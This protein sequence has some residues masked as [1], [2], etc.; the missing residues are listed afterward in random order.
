MSS[1]PQQTEPPVQP[2]HRT[3]PPFPTTQYVP[4]RALD[5]IDGIAYALHLFLGSHMIESEQ[6]CRKYDPKMERLYFATGF[7]LIQCVKGLMS[8]EDEDLVDAIAHVRHGNAIASQHRKRAASLPTRLA[9]LVVGSL[10]TS[11]VGFIKSMTPVERH[12]ELVYAE[13]LFEKALL[14]IVYSG[15]WLAFIKEALNMRTTINIYRQLGKYLDAVDAEAQ[16]RGLGPE[17]RAVDAHFRSGVYLGVGVSNL[18]LSLMPPRLLAVVELF[19]YQGDRRLG[20]ASLQRAGGWSAASD[21]PA[22]GAEQEGLR[23]TICDMALLMFHLVLSSFTF[24]GV[25]IRMAQKILDYHA[26]R[27][28]NGVFFLFGQGRL[29]LCRA[30]PAAALE[31]YR[32]ALRAQD[33]LRNLHH[34]SFWEMAVA[35]LAL[36]EVDESLACWRTLAAEAT[37]SKSVYAYGAAACLLEREDAT[38]AEAKEAAALMAQ[39]PALRQRI[40][41]KSIPLEKFVARKARKFAQ[42]RARLALP[43]LEL[44]YVLGALAHAPRAAVLGRMLPR[45]AACLEALDAHARDPAAYG[46]RGDGEGD[47]DGEG[48]GGGDGESGGEGEYWD[49]RALALFLKGVCLRYVAHPDPDAVLD[50]AEAASVEEGRAAAEAGARAA[51]EAVFELG[52]RVVYDH[53]LVYCAHYELARLLACQ[54]DKASARV[55]LELVLSGKPL[56]VNASM[57]KGKYSLENAVRIRANAALEALEHTSRL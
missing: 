40:A 22:V 30:Q 38:A 11:G 7:G 39:V 12:A 8:F 27:Y 44:A 20:L 5:D 26:Q 24:D 33:Q 10:N 36:W 43:A 18:V 2:W 19:G 42:Q 29:H 51:F 3:P 35:H 57:R 49:D 6:Y 21:V 37:W 17:D 52:P 50:A 45:V 9:G 14:G 23:R 1:Q 41:G 31:C 16:A 54:G 13:S 46:R 4:N 34:V 56:E 32:Q 25:D 28:P 48:G 15:D 53:Y 55:Q 47:S